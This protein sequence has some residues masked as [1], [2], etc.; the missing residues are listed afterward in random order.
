MPFFR[1]FTTN[2]CGTLTECLDLVEAKQADILLLSLSPMEPQTSL[3]PHTSADYSIFYKAGEF[4][5]NPTYFIDGMTTELWIYIWSFFFFFFLGLLVSVKVYRKFYHIHNITVS[6]TA[7]FQMNF[8]LNQNHE[9]PTN[10]HEKFVSWKIQI[11]CQSV[12]NI[13]IACA[14]SAFIFA[15]LSVQEAKIPFETFE[16]LSFKS[17]HVVCIYWYLPIT[18]RFTDNLGGD[19][20]VKK[21]FVGRFNTNSCNRVMRE[22]SDEAL[23]S[24]NNL[25]FISPVY[26]FR[27]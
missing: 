7:M 26:Q 22:Q 23:C 16:D 2:Y 24:E 3:M 5:L 21:E 25:A 6:D 20:L 9:L 1:R 11:L 8:I 13:V 19:K 18:V 10:A 12:F 4:N 27:E 17:S 15:L 14:F